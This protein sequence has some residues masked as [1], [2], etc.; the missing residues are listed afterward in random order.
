MARR[1]RFQSCVESLDAAV[2][3]AEGGADGLELCARLDVDGLTPDIALVEAVQARV[4]LPV[5]VMIRPRDGD[6]VYAGSEIARMTADIRRMAALGVNG[7]VVG[8]LNNDGTVDD[9]AMEQLIDAAGSC[10][11]TFHRAIDR[12]PDLDAAC[13]ALMELGLDFVLTS[14]GAA[15]AAE[16]A[17]A[18]ARLVARGGDDLAV[19]AAGRIRADNVAALV[20]ATGVSHVHARLITGTCTTPADAQTARAS[21]AEMMAALRAI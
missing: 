6:Y 20:A 8:A 21:V 16:G 1:V 11:V 4:H 10:L 18:I 7:V 2:A 13:D 15:T 17:P 14:G 3:S 12:A 19:I 9:G 5:S